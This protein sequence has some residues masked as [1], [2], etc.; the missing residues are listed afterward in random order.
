[1]LPNRVKHM[2]DYA[3]QVLFGSLGFLILFGLALFL[4][5]LVHWMEG[6]T[7]VPIWLIDGAQ[8]VEIFIFV[9]DAFSFVGLLLYELYV[10]GAGLIAS[11]NER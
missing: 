8:G 2:S 11:R 9:V 4:A 3:W 1:M 10:F 7:W 6:E 5:Y